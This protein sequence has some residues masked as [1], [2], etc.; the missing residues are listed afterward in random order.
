MSPTAKRS[1][2]L[3][4]T[5]DLL[6]LKALEAAPLHGVGVFKRIGEITNSAVEVSYG[7]LFPALH[8]ME[9]KGWLAAEWRDSDN[10]LRAKYYRLTNA[11]RRQL[12]HETREWQQIVT[13]VSLALRSR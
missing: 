13:T 8:R 12:A 4:G 3:R 11:G 1:G 6:V 5:L 7:S 9:V 10:N 2:Q